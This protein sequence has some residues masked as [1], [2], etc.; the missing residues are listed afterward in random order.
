MAAPILVLALG[1]VVAGLPFIGDALGNLLGRPG[2]VHHAGLVEMLLP[3]GVVLAGVALAWIDFGMRT[4][5]QRGVLAWLPAAERLFK[6]RWYID[7]LYQKTFVA[8]TDFVARALH[9]T[10]T[11]G[12]DRAGDGIAAGTLATGAAAAR[13]HT[14]RLPIFVGTALTVLT[15]VAL[16]LALG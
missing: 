11:R 13:T 15:A 12:L 16:S 9:F 1:A 4:A 2:E 8:L 10:E 7:A 14:G 5:P 3:V 6:N